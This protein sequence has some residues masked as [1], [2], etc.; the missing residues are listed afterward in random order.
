MGTS[1]VFS[2]F[3]PT[4]LFAGEPPVRHRAVTIAGFQNAIGS[5]LKRGTLLGRS[6]VG[7]AVT[8][9]KASG[10][11]TGNGTIAMDGTTPVLAAGLNGTYKVRMTAATAF[12]VT[13]PTGA[14]VGTGATGTPFSNEI[15]FTVTVGGVAFVAGDGFD[16]A[17]NAEDTYLVSVKTATD[18][19]QT[20]SAILAADTDTSAGAINSPAYFEG[21]FAGEMMTIDASWTIATVQAALRQSGSALFVRSVGVLG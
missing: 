3:D 15:K 4:S 12:T 18:G 6:S 21:E 5:K 20:P 1:N 17:I 11:N 14:T 7:D 10:A 16:I 9:V 19:S 2:T 13:D 8:S